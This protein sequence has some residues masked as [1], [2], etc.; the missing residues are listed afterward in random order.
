MLRLWPR[1]D[2]FLRCRHGA[3]IARSQRCRNDANRTGSAGEVGDLAYAEPKPPSP[4]GPC[5]RAATAEPFASVFF[6]LGFLYDEMREAVAAA[7]AAVQF[8][9]SV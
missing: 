8:A 5:A 3:I 2:R 9:P 6:S 7:M 1:R 4:P